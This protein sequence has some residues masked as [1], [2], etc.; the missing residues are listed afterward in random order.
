MS[1]FSKTVFSDA[2]QTQKYCRVKNAIIIT[3]T[4]KGEQVLLNN[5]TS[6]SYSVD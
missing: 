6:I 3:N 1:S 5:V 2:T 4:F